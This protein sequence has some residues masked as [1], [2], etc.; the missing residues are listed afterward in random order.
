M[1]CM[2][3]LGG[4]I[5]WVDFGNITECYMIGI[6][7]HRTNSQNQQS[8]RAWSQYRTS[9]RARINMIKDVMLFKVCYF[10]YGSGIYL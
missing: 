7:I 8:N 3:D 6:E 1:V 9:D 2:Q 5:G 10:T 4:K